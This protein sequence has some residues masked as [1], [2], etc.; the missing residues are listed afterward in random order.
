MDYIV[1][2]IMKNKLLKRRILDIS[3]KHK[4]SHIGSCLTAVDIIDEIYA[5]K[6]PEEKFVLSSGHAGLALYCVLEKYGYRYFKDD[7]LL[8]DTLDAEKIFEHHGVHP[9]RCEECHIDCSSGSLGQGL[10]IAVGMALADRKK[11]VYC[12]VSDGEM[13]EGSIWEALRIAKEQKLYNLKVYV[14]FNGY[15]AYKDIPLN[16]FENKLAEAYTMLL[17]RYNFI[18]IPGSEWKNVSFLQGQ[19]AHY[20][21]MNEEQYKEALELVA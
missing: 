1:K 4:L 3:Y 9:D 18:D 2:S 5:I 7:K 20:V 21:A 8:V 6:K 14:N 15:G 17:F 19:Q 11:N 10:P 12:L 16:C 13:S